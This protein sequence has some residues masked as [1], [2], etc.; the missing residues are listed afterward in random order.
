MSATKII[1]LIGAGPNVGSAVAKLFASKGYKVATT[2]RG[3]S[4]L[5]SSY[6]HIKADVSQPDKIK[7]IFAAVKKQYGNA[8]NVVVYNAASFQP[9]GADPLSIPQDKFEHDLA[10]N[11]TSPYLAAQ[12]ATRAFV[13]LPPDF[14]KSFIY[15]GNG[16]N[17]QVLPSFVTAGLGKSATAHVIDC[18]AKAYKDKGWTFYYADERKADGG[19]AFRDISGENHAERYWELSQDREQQP[20]MHTFV[21]GVGYKNFA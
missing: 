4:K 9:A 2:S 12:E 5:D 10:V 16:L 19:F 8:P 3:D 6:F 15:T 17:M 7:G 1:L 11:T 20:W 14:P 18:A 13:D 21:G